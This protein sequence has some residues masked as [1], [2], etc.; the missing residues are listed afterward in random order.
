ML[1]TFNRKS[2]SNNHSQI[3]KVEFT[4]GVG[5]HQQNWLLKAVSPETRDYENGRVGDDRERY[6]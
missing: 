2:K 1:H 3:T 6:L 5:D 4:G